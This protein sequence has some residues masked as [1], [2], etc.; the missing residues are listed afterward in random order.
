MLTVSTRLVLTIVRV[1]RDSPATATRA[2]VLRTFL[3]L[4][5]INAFTDIS[6][7]VIK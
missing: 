1:N 7:I 2:P 6:F 3:Y 5:L 4:R